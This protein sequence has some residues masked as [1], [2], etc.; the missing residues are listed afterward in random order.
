M[1]ELRFSINRINFQ[2]S[3][4]RNIIKCKQL[5]ISI[6]LATVY[7]I[8]TDAVDSHVLACMTL[9][10]YNY[11]LYIPILKKTIRF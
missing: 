1:H 8:S 10:I 7:I 5:L 11:I 9:F 3:T 6:G 2:S 4:E